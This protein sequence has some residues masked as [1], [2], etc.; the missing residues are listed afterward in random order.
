ME[1]TA[2]VEF[3]AMPGNG[4]T[5]NV[6]EAGPED[7]PLVILLHGF[8]EFWFGWRHQIGVLAA[9]GF[10]VGGPGPRGYNLS[11]KPKG[12]ARYDIDILAADVIALATHYTSEPFFLVG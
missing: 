7:G 12:I 10:R 4:V 1:P 5:L 8:P 9:A 11:D 3:V 6:A 2:G